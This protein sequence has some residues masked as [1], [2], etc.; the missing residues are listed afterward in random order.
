[1]STDLVIEHISRVREPIG[2]WREGRYREVLER[3]LRDRTLREVDRAGYA[4]AAQPVQTLHALPDYEAVQAGA[5][6]YDEPLTPEQ[7]AELPAAAWFE[8]RLTVPIRPL[9]PS[10]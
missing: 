9:E 4:F 8:V 6:S 5:P 3:N 2:T 1:M 10:P 7:V